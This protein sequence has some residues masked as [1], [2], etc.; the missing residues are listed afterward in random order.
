MLD[1]L[2]G[3]QV[4]PEIAS[5]VREILTQPT[6]SVL[7][8][9][10]VRNV[11]PAEVKRG[12]RM[13][14]PFDRFGTGRRTEFFKGM[15]SG[16]FSLM[17][18]GLIATDL[19]GIIGMTRTKLR[20]TNPF[21]PKI[22]QQ[23]AVVDINPRRGKGSV[24]FQK[25]E[26]LGGRIDSAVERSARANLTFPRVEELRRSGDLIFEPFDISGFRKPAKTTKAR[27]KK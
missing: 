22:G 25:P 23:L 19:R 1:R 2:K 9:F 6:V 12:E 7:E 17:D 14:D 15:K 4:T 11:N 26:T 5:R 13:T 20:Q 18:E 3:G 10:N 8:D 21:N 16:Q 27:G 24:L